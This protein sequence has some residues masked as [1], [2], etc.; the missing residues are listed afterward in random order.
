MAETLPLPGSL[1]L[2]FV[3]DTISSHEL[4]EDDD[5]DEHVHLGGPVEPNEKDRVT[6]CTW[7]KDT[8]SGELE[9]REKAKGA[10]DL[11]GPH[12]SLG[13]DRGMHIPGR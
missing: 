9:F 2:R 1:L 6:R 4:V 5:S 11:L 12:P 3:R 13:A 7:G 10:D 8:P